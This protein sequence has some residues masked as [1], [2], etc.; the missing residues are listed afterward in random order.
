[1]S[2]GYSLI[3]F[4]VVIGIL[5]LALGSSLAFLTSSLKGSNKASISAETKQNGQAVLD[6]LEKQIRNA[7]GAEL[8]VTSPNYKH[9]RLPKQSATPGTSNYLHIKCFDTD[10]S[11]NGSIR[12]LE[13]TNAAPGDGLF[14]TNTFITSTDPVS[15]VDIDNCAFD[16]DVGSAG[17]DSPPVVS[18]SF[19]VNQGVNAP[20]RQDF[21]AN[22]QFQTTISLRK[23]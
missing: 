16:V 3:E 17:V 21:K 1:M 14:T 13:S 22:V 15:G 6:S 2:K 20:S 19:I 23:Y 18:L 12:V 10:S 4:L 7:S 11:V 9:I 5:V 8:V